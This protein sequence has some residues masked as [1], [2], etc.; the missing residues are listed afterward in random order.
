[1]TSLPEKFDSDLPQPVE[2]GI[3]LGSVLKGTVARFVPGSLTV[4]SPFF[5]ATL[6]D[7]PSRWLVVLG[8]FGLEIGAIATGFGAGLATLRRW[9]FPEA[10]V[11][12][13][14]SVIAGL[15]SPLALGIVSIFTQGASL[16]EIAVYSLVAGFMMAVLM[17]FPWLTPSEGDTEVAVDGDPGISQLPT[18]GR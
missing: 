16:G 1:M 14:R 6:L 3:S 18:A 7:D 12:G 10:K 13:R 11:D 8:I 5:V 9:L 15:M 2:R 4:F 17:F